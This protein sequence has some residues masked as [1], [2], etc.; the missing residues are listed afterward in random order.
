MNIRGMRRLYVFL[1]YISFSIACA[2]QGITG[3]VVDEHGNAIQYANVAL[4]Q[5]TDSA[6]IK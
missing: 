3:K 6:F 2:A 4:L 5:S 1:V